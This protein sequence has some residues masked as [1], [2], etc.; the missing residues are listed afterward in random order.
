M[1]EGAVIICHYNWNKFYPKNSKRQ[2]KALFK[3]ANSLRYHRRKIIEECWLGGD[4]V[5]LE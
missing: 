1:D 2:L 5:H 3:E 4:Y